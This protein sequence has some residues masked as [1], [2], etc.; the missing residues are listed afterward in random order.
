MFIY[1]INT[2]LGAASRSGPGS[3]SGNLASLVQECA[4]KLKQAATHVTWIVDSVDKVLLVG[5]LA[6]RML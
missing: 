4:K 5:H 2:S 1:S 6:R 3:F